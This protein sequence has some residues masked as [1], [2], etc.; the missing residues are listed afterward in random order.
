MPTLEVVSYQRQEYGNLLYTQALLKLDP[1]LLKIAVRIT[2]VIPRKDLH[3]F[4]RLF[5][6]IRGRIGLTT[7]SITKQMLD[8]EFYRICL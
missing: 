3:S 2:S 4:Y 7:D 8:S 6:G 5:Q 1:I